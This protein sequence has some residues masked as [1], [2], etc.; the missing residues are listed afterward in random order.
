MILFFTILGALILLLLFL[1]RKR[2]EDKCPNV[3]D[4]NFKKWQ[5]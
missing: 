2:P 4:I 1:I 3:T 5:E